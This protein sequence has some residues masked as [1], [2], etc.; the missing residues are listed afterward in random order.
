MIDAT[1][2]KY[3]LAVITSAG[4]K[5][6]VNE[7]LRGLQWEE[8]QGE[9]AVRLTAEIQNQQTQYGW[10]HQLFPMAGR[11][12]LS[13]NWGE[14]WREIWRG[15]IFDRDYRTDPVGN[16]T[17]T[18]YDMLNYLKSEDNRFWKVGTKGRTIISDLAKWWNIPLGKME[19]PDIAL[20][21]QLLK[22][23][24]INGFILDIL[25]QS[26][27]RGAGKF[28]VRSSEGKMDIVKVGGNTVV[29]H[30][31]SGDSVQVASDQENIDDLVTR[32]IIVG[33]EDRDARDPIYDRM[34]GRT[35]F[36]IIQK[37]VT[38][39]K[40]ENPAVAKQTAQEI[41][42]EQGKPKRFRRIEVPDLPFLRKGDKV[43]ISAGTMNGYYIVSGVHHN[44]DSLSMS[45]EVED[46]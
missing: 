42:K 26:K 37:M 4:T 32:V 18:A 38:R 21:K 8:P 25:Q 3:D 10:L 36:G 41:I 23:E 13:S 46:L 14:G 43:H 44:P 6:H 17:V 2:I 15:T 45:L 20:G 27:D 39:Q 16:F 29:Y 33:S 5:L 35:E 30:F 40:S 12:V 19:G 22:N 9:L 31:G 11:L 1:K 7:F 24:P 28:I 34:D